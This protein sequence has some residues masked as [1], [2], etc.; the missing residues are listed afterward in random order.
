MNPK[1]ITK[2]QLTVNIS[3]KVT[4]KMYIRGQKLETLVENCEAAIKRFATS[5]A[6]G[7][8][9]TSNR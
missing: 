7:W 5:S 2:G 1:R 8:T 4:R 3:D 6:N 9:E